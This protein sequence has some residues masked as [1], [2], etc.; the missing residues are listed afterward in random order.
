VTRHEATTGLKLLGACLG[1][2][3]VTLIIGVDV[4][5]GIGQ[6]V[7]GQL[8]AL[9]GAVLYACASIYGK[10][11]SHLTPA[12]SAAGTMIWASVILVPLSLAI[13]EPWT[14]TPSPKAV[15]AAITLAIACTGFALL[16]YFRLLK[17]L[18]SLG[19]ASQ[20][21]LRAKVG[22]MLGVV[23]LGEQV[24]FVVGLGLLLAIAG[25]AAI[26]AP[27]RYKP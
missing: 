22:V 4:L 3:G 17:T 2:L 26:N 10:R 27:V 6:K 14:L 18:G 23:L 5:A 16:I 21:Y 7:S 9:A 15:A 12:A 13:D 20:A 8:A 19:T 11:F 24:T 25:V 1:L